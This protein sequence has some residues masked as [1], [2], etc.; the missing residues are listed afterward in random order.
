MRKIELEMYNSL[1]FSIRERIEN[2]DGRFLGFG[3]DNFRTSLENLWRKGMK[4]KAILIL[5][6]Y[7]YSRRDSTVVK[8]PST[9]YLI[10]DGI[11]F[12]ELAELIGL[13]KSDMKFDGLK[14]NFEEFT[15]MHVDLNDEIDHFKLS[16]RRKITRWML[17]NDID[18]A[19]NGGRLCR[20]YKIDRDKFIMACILYL[21]SRYNNLKVEV[22]KNQWVY[23]NAGSS[24]STILEKRGIV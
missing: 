10:R 15:K 18:P 11:D 6:C 1:M 2:L 5:I 23:I 24:V 9:V 7:H 8:T 16:R 20:L 3:I 14:I 21:N 22:E 4:G 13:S 19:K 17:E 12:L